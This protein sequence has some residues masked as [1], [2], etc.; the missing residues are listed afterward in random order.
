VAH[1]S[2]DTN[3]QG[4]AN[5]AKKDVWEVL[6]SASKIIAALGIPVVLGVGGW[7]IQK[8]VSNQTVSKDYV[9]LA[10]SILQAK[11]EAGNDSAKGLRKWAV[12][13]LSGYK[14]HSLSWLRSP[15]S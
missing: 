8:S 12:A 3:A 6:E 7:Y 9:T 14:S 13:L 2:E 11:Q 5:P 15:E 10:T 1:S 4:S